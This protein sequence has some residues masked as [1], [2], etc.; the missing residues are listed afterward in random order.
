MK[1]IDEVLKRNNITPIGYLKKGKATIISTGTLKYVIKEGTIDK[2]VLECLNSRGF[3]YKPQITMDSNYLIEE[4][5]EDVDTTNEQKVLDLTKIL[6]LLHKKTSFYKEISAYD[7]KTV[8]EELLSDYDCLHKYY[9]NRINRIDN[10]IIYSPS[11]Y[12][13]SRGI[14]H[15]LS[16]IDKGIEYTHNWYKK[17]KDLDSVRV[18][19]IHNNLE[20]SHFINNYLISWDKAKIDIPIYDIYKLYNKYYLE[21][22]FNDLLREYESEYPLKDYE[23]EL[24]FI[25]ILMPNKIDFTDTEYNMCLN[26]SREVDRLYKS[27]ELIKKSIE[28]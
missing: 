5:I 4:Y 26:I 12:V 22:S 21:F 13:F 10:K 20:L 9:I 2:K 28:N 6:S 19:V 24:L 7:Y 3:R 1:V 25:L 27:N 8:Y 18:S 16:S 11:D 17:I 23:R 15:I 14:S